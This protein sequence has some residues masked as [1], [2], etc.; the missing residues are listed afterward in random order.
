M[1]SKAESFVR[2]TVE[3]LVKTGV[4]VVFE[5][6]L[7][8]LTS[9]L[10]VVC[11]TE[12]EAAEL[13]NRAGTEKLKEYWRGRHEGAWSIRRHAEKLEPAILM[14][15]KLVPATTPLELS[16]RDE[17]KQKLKQAKALGRPKS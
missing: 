7:N 10:F 6:T 3:T 9:V 17:L 2:V 11:A 8:A 13:R 14:L 12:C 1:A 15:Q 16:S 4:N 5:Q